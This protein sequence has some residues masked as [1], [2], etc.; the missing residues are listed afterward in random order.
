M[1][2]LS[3][4]A[5]ALVLVPAGAARNQ[6]APTLRV[7]DLAPLTVRGTGFVPAE[8]VRLALRPGRP[9]AVVRTVSAGPS[10]S[11]RAGFGL[12]AVEPCRGAVVITA[13]GSRGS[14]ASV[15]R[16]CRPPS[17]EG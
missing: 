17:L 11:F 13:T 7:V 5:L 9:R 10:G 8:K 12:A 16:P 14:R 6:R 1:R 15:R 2:R 3:I 4:V